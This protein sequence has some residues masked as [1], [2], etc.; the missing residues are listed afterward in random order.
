MAHENVNAKAK[1]DRKLGCG[2]PFTLLKTSK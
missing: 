1:I 2:I